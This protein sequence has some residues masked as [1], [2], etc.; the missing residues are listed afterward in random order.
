MERCSW[1]SGRSAAV[2]GPCGI[3][4]ATLGLPAERWKRWCAGC[5]TVKGNLLDSDA[6]VLL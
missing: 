1:T 5:A 3:K 2:R 6:W 4:Q